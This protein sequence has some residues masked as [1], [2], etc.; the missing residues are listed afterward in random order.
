MDK[1]LNSTVEILDSISHQLQ[2]QQ[3]Q[4]SQMKEDLAKLQIYFEHEQ[5]RTRFE[6][7]VDS[8]E[9]FLKNKQ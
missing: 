7:A 4:I 5:A 3:T 8:L 6:R 9:K 1:I 2:N